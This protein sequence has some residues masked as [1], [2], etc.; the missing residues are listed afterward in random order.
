VAT[1][2]TIERSAFSPTFFADPAKQPLRVKPPLA[3]LHAPDNE[4]ISVEQLVAAA[5]P[6]TSADLAARKY[7]YGYRA[8]FAFWPERFDYVVVMHFARPV[9]NPVPRHLTRIAQGSYFDLYRVAK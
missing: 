8:Y 3:H 9:E 5:D 2:A 4:P 6:M 1:I 7:R